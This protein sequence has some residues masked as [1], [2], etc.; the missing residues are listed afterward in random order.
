[1]IIFYKYFVLL[2]LFNWIC[3]KDLNCAVLGECINIILST[4]AFLNCK[5]EER[6]QSS[7]T[8]PDRDSW[9]DWPYE[10][11]YIILWKILYWNCIQFAIK[12]IKTQLF[13]FIMSAAI[14]FNDFMWRFVTCHLETCVHIVSQQIFSYFRFSNQFLKYFDR[15]T[16]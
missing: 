15:H 4:K 2:R 5:K 9:Q 13:N 7:Q 8:H 12:I 6:I 1:M 10:F 14:S 3:L 11:Y 16:K